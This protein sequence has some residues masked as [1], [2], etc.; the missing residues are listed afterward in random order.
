MDVLR[1]FSNGL[2][3]LLVLPLFAVAA[4]LA[5][6]AA[7]RCRG[8]LN[9][10]ADGWHAGSVLLGERVVCSAL[11]LFAAF[12]TPMRFES[13]LTRLW[14]KKPREQTISE[15]VVEVIPLA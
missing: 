7:L 3:L 2:I 15:V 6:Y 5:V 14:R 9:V 8:T 12:Q 11:R 13:A 1:Y 10:T 4:Y